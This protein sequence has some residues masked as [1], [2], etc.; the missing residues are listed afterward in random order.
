LEEGKLYIFRVN[1]GKGGHLRKL[2]DL[3]IDNVSNIQLL[4]NIGVRSIKGYLNFFISENNQ[5]IKEYG[6]FYLY[7]DLRKN[8][9]VNRTSF[10]SILSF[11]FHFYIK[12]EDFDDGCYMGDLED[13]IY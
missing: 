10:L 13:F 12:F 6:N 1:R 4:K 5:L 11:T 8:D 2:Y 3:F 9:R 7:V